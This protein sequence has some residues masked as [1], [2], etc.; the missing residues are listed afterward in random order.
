MPAGGLGG[1]AIIAAVHPVLVMPY[2][3]FIANSCVS[4]QNG[5]CYWW[6][7]TALQFGGAVLPLVVVGLGP[8]GWLTC[9]LHAWRPPARLRV[10]AVLQRVAGS[11]AVLSPAAA[12]TLGTPGT[13][14]GW[15]D[16]Q[17]VRR[18]HA[19]RVSA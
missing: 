5:V 17:A 18:A 9:W 8:R 7:S 13:V 11:R 6:F 4:F 12:E 15:S 1:G 14:S 10:P 3:S 19:M 2:R 16:S